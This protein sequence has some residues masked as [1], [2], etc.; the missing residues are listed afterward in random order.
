MTRTADVQA[1]I[2]LCAIVI[3]VVGLFLIYPL[4]SYSPSRTTHHGTV[5]SVD[6]PQIAPAPSYAVMNE[7]GAHIGYK[8]SDKDLNCLVAA[9]FVGQYV[10]FVVEHDWDTGDWIISMSLGVHVFG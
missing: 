9:T 1:F 5:L 2:A 7:S 8:I 10:S 6:C 3:T 4:P